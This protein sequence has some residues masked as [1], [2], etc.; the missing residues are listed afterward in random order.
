MAKKPDPIEKFRTLAELGQALLDIV[1]QS[2]MLRRPRRAAKP[3]KPRV[4]KA[5]APKAVAPKPAPK[6][7]RKPVDPRAAALGQAAE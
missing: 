7:A 1:R 5:V 6:P 2:G 4:P 3:R